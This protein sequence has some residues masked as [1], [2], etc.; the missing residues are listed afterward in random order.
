MEY[1]VAAGLYS[2][3]GYVAGTREDLRFWEV[4]MG[5]FEGFMVMF[6]VCVVK[7][8]GGDSVFLCHSGCAKVDCLQEI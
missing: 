2:Y 5:G 4:V 6:S 7:S 3:H 8:R 1:F